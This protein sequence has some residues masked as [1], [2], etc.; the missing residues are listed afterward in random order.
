MKLKTVKETHELHRLNF[1][2]HTGPS[3]ATFTQIDWGHCKFG[4]WQKVFVTHFTAISQVSCITD[5]HHEIIRTV[6]PERKR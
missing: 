2:S 5:G 3:V 1:P 6:G 4:T